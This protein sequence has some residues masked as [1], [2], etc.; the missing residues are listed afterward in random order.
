[1]KLHTLI[2]RTEY[3]LSQMRSDIM[4]YRPR[5]NCVPVEYYAGRVVVEHRRDIDDQQ[6]VT[7]KSIAVEDMWIRVAPR[8]GTRV[9]E[10]RVVCGRAL[11]WT[12]VDNDNALKCGCVLLCIPCNTV[13]R[14]GRNTS[15]HFAGC[16]ISETNTTCRGGLRND[17]RL[18]VLAQA[19]GHVD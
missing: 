17:R 8:A 9:S 5:L 11:V 2:C 10:M 1:M 12:V 15:P 6:Y 4:S 7:A 19:E 13:H 16:A 14:T 18:C 3:L